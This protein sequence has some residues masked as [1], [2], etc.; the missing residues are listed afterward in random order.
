MQNKKKKTQKS[1]KSSEREKELP[2]NLDDKLLDNMATRSM[3]GLM[4]GHQP[5]LRLPKDFDLKYDLIY[6]AANQ[7]EIK[8]RGNSGEFKSPVEMRV[9]IEHDPNVKRNELAYNFKTCKFIIYTNLKD[10]ELDEIITNPYTEKGLPR[11]DIIVKSF[12]DI[13]P[14]ALLK[15]FTTQAEVM[16]TGQAEDYKSKFL[17]GQFQTEENTPSKDQT[18][19]KKKLKKSKPRKES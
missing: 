3:M 8:F 18:K 10:E 17:P 5:G 16:S 12:G 9:Q 14:S 6:A 15:Y 13:I 4:P 19:K 1:S 11:G 2:F 7:T